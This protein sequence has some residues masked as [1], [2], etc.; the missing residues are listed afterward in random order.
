MEARGRLS[1]LLRDGSLRDALEA[2]EAAGWMHAEM[3]RM[4][5]PFVEMARALVLMGR[6][7]VADKEGP[8]VREL[9]RRLC[10]LVDMYPPSESTQTSAPSPNN[11]SAQTFFGSSPP[12]PFAGAEH[13]AASFEIHQSGDLPAGAHTLQNTRSFDLRP[14]LMDLQGVPRKVLGGGLYVDDKDSDTPRGRRHAPDDLSVYPFGCFPGLDPV[15]ANGRRIR[16]FTQL[17]RLLAN[18]IS[19]PRRLPDGSVPPPPVPDDPICPPALGGA[20]S[21]DPPLFHAQYDDWHHAVRSQHDLSRTRAFSTLPERIQRAEMELGFLSA[22]RHA[23][24]GLR[25]R[26]Q[27]LETERRRRLEVLRE[28]V[29]EVCARELGREV[30]LAEPALEEVLSLRKSGVKGVFGEMVEGRGMRLPHG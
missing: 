26:L 8:G 25:Q 16:R 2:E 15:E 7:R 22:T 17:L 20:V 30:G 9:V 23:L 10:C 6:I 4:I 27:A 13:A 12:P 1:A 11:H 5:W 19:P 14:L 3:G 24:E 29:A 28:T 18:L 21:F